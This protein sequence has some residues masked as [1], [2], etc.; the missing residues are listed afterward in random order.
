MEGGH[1]P[2][3]FGGFAGPI[4]AN[5]PTQQ[6]DH[7]TRQP[8]SA[9]VS[10]NSDSHLSTSAWWVQVSRFLISAEAAAMPF[11]IAL[12]KC[13]LV[14]DADRAGWPYWKLRTLLKPN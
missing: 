13:D 2:W 14:S 5:D 6:N 12:N 8:V 3:G 7:T 4:R 1:G 9:S 11:N 10:L